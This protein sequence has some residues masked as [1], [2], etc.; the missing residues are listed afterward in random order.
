[1]LGNLVASGLANGAVYALVAV[2]L[3]VV[4]KS[5]SVVNFAHGEGFMLGGFL[6]WTLY[7]GLGLPYAIATVAA[8]IGAALIG[9]ITERVAFRPLIRSSIVSLVLA[10]TGLSFVLRGVARYLWGGRGS[11]TPFPPVFGIEPVQIGDV[12]LSS[13]H[14]IV[15]AG[16]LVAMLLFLAFFRY[17]KTGKMMRATADNQRAAALVGVRVERISSIT[18][19]LGA[20]MGGVAAVLAA[21]LTLLYPDM[22]G[23]LLIRAFAAALLGGLGSLAGAVVGGLSL[24]LIENLAGGYIDGSLTDVAPFV[25]IILVLM[26][27]PRGLFGP[28]LTV[29][30]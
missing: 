28:R 19:A 22:G 8:V 20:A 27:R 14:L 7:V 15:V 21:P 24:G 17:T 18:W 11:D 6:A 26:I 1:V 3:V 5:T 23:P 10:T 12:V 30:L 16:A 25:L 2:G 13:Q 4:Y 29:K 9:V